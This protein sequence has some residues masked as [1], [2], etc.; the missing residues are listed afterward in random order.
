MLEV[1][2]IFAGVL[3][4]LE[5]FKHHFTKGLL[6]Y[7]I[8]ALALLFVF[9][10]ASSYFDLGAFF[11]KE[12]TFSKTGAVIAEDVDEDIENVDLRGSKTLKTLSEK[13][14]DFIRH[15]LDS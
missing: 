6:K 2:L 1:I 7:G 11:N 4:I 5:L 15:I 12:N 13:T 9:L 3:V 8:V 10:L 14:K